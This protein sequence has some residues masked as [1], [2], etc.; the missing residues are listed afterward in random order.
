MADD[1]NA[2][3]PKKPTIKITQEP[4]KIELQPLPDG[5]PTGK[6]GDNLG[7]PK[8]D[9]AG[10]GEPA[11][12]GDESQGTG[13]ENPQTGEPGEPAEGGER[14]PQEENPDDK[15]EKEEEKPEDK[16]DDDKGKEEGDKENNED[17]PKDKET[18]KEKAGEGKPGEEKPG[19]KPDAKAP[20]EGMP[21]TGAGKGLKDAASQGINNAKDQALE[22]VEKKVVQKAGEEVAKKAVAGAVTAGWGTVALAAT[23]IIS[24]YG[25]Y[26]LAFLIII[27]LVIILAFQSGQQGGS[28]QSEPLDAKAN[29][30]DIEKV[31]A[32]T[33]QGQDSG[34]APTEDL[35]GQS[36]QRTDALNSE[37]LAALEPAVTNLKDKINSVLATP[38]LAT[39]KVS[40]LQDA[41]NL[42]AEIKISDDLKNKLDELRKLEAIPETK[43][44][45]DDANESNDQRK[46]RAKL[47]LEVDSQFSI[48][49]QKLQDINDQLINI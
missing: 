45:V 47:R 44:K 4:E 5:L 11:A 17:K 32:A 43:L 30:R 14:G 48:L 24:K 31:K 40:Q 35:A 25:K 23:D 9:A 10:S 34:S 1:H 8:K 26:I 27:A 29:T 19:G 42:L 16:K 13:G 49:W 6:E 28:G 33:L 37:V 22:N 18:G 36:L 46:Q 15:K 12:N 38:N 41:E 20:G 2:A 39:D 7:A 3:Q 21:D